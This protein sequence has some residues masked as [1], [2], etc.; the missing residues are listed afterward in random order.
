MDRDDWRDR[1]SYVLERALPGDVSS[2]RISGICH[3]SS[4]DRCGILL[5][6]GRKRSF[7]RTMAT[8]LFK[9]SLFAYL[10]DAL[11]DAGPGGDRVWLVLDLE[12][13]ANGKPRRESTILRAVY[14][15]GR[16]LVDQKRISQNHNLALCSRR[17]RFDS[18]ERLYA[19]R[20]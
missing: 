7:R 14:G 2:I 17:G 16:H 6:S 19:R 20:K 8:G 3:S 11:Q 1:T 9:D 13:D 5:R 15:K 10:A 12:N 18:C 4:T